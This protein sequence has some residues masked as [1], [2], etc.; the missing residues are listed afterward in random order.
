MLTVSIL[1]IL[2]L[3]ALFLITSF[4]WV[5]PPPVAGGG[6]VVPGRDGA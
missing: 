2:A 3:V 1:Q 5:G 4:F 6:C